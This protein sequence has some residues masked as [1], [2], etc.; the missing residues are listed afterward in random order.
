MKILVFIAL[1]TCS[2]MAVFAQN[3]TKRIDEAITLATFQHHSKA[4]G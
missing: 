3:N 4:L 1:F 2:S